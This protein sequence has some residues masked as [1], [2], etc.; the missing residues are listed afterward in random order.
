M[1]GPSW[2]RSISAVA[3]SSPP[4]SATSGPRHRARA[5]VRQAAAA[6]GAGVCG[7][8]RF[9]DQ[10][11]EHARVD[12]LRPGLQAVAVTFRDDRRP[13][14]RHPPRPASAGAWG[15]RR[16]SGRVLTR[17]G[18]ASSPHRAS[19]SRSVLT[20]LL[21]CNARMA[22]RIACFA[23][24]CTS[25]SPTGAARR[26]EDADPHDA[27]HHNDTGAP[28][29]RMVRESTPGNP[30]PIDD[31]L[32]V[33][34]LA[35]LRWQMTTATESS[36]MA[37]TR[38][39]SSGRTRRPARGRGAAM[40]GKHGRG[41]VRTL[42]TVCVGATLIAG[43]WSSST[44]LA[45]MGSVA[46]GGA[47]PSGP[48]F[49]RASRNR[50]S[51]GFPVRP[52]QGRSRTTSTARETSAR[53]AA[54]VVH[55]PRGP[56]AKLRLD[57]PLSRTEPRASGAGPLGAGSM[58]SPSRDRRASVTMRITERPPMARTRWRRGSHAMRRSTLVV[59]LLVAGMPPDARIRSRSTRRRSGRRRSRLPSRPRIR[60]APRHR[61]RS[62]TRSPQRTI[63]GLIEVEAI[64]GSVV[65]G[66]TAAG[67]TV[68][69][70]LS[71]GSTVVLD[72]GAEARPGDLG[73]GYA[74]GALPGDDTVSGSAFVYEAGHWVAADD[75]PRST[76]GVALGR[77][78]T[79]GRLVVG[80][81]SSRT[82]TSRRRGST[83]STLGSPTWSSL[84]TRVAPV[85]GS[86]T[87]A[88]A[89]CTAGTFGLDYDEKR[90][91]G[92]IS[93]SGHETRAPPAVRR[94]LE[95]GRRH[96]PPP[97]RRWHPDTEALDQP[98]GRLRP[99]FRASSSTCRASSRGTSKAF[100]RGRVDRRGRS[101]IGRVRL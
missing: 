39:T 52:Q 64:D 3:T 5:S 14:R 23:G 22:R 27:A 55:G 24:R 70:D 101:R 53:A 59:V 54:R 57:R 80:T 72:V 87:S 67:E 32:R 31:V 74:V 100:A 12:D 28:T 30:S 41:V 66:M 76:G 89:G 49:L 26:S 17:S 47:A 94:V 78:A 86:P 15:G 33:G 9:G 38:A 71:D 88:M 69:Y 44:A 7:G 46:S 34:C 90:S 50:P 13:R 82:A 36:G 81:L 43:G 48:M 4:T 95:L 21:G 18:D 2:R 20:V 25:R 29:R 92:T 75:R 73:G 97:R 42:S 11:E 99:R 98:G 91:A 93:R 77:I 61:R 6:S 35:A 60:R 16:A 62:P 10:L 1:S 85:A 84:S 96:R 51:P 56:V 37:E 63:P 45:S 40:V 19:M 68:L 65:L 8:A 58:P 83:T 79:D